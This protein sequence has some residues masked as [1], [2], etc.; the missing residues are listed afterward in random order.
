MRLRDTFCGCEEV[1]EDGSAGD[2]NHKMW[3]IV[4]RNTQYGRLPGI[5]HWKRSGGSAE[6]R[7]IRI[8]PAGATMAAFCRKPL[9]GSLEVSP[10]P[11]G[12]GRVRL[13][14]SLLLAGRKKVRSRVRLKAELRTGAVWSSAFRR[15]G[16]AS[17]DPLQPLARFATKV[18][19]AARLLAGKVPWHNAPPKLVGGSSRANPPVRL[20]PQETSE[21][22]E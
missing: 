22:R 1:G 2:P 8:P 5:L 3:F 16:T 15:F 9:R 4:P 14:R 7:T 20:H 21:N 10:Y 11:A 17:A 6:R 12:D 13:P 19:K 18:E